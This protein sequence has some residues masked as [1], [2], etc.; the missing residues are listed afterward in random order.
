MPFPNNNF[1]KKNTGA[2]VFFFEYLVTFGHMTTFLW[3]ILE[4][5]DQVKRDLNTVK[6]TWL[7][8]LVE[9]LVILAIPAFC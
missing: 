7:F 4:K 9:F 5:M 6:L 8:I 3:K 2:A 1:L